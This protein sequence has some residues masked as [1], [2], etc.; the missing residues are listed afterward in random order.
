MTRKKKTARRQTPVST[1][2]RVMKKNRSVGHY[3]LPYGEVITASDVGSTDE[4]LDAYVKGG[5]LKIITPEAPVVRDDEPVTRGSVNTDPGT[6]EE[7]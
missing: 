2:Y 6:P 7:G 5:V 4:T 1:M 3:P